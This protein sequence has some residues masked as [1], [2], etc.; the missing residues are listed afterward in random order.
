M[1]HEDLQAKMQAL[2]TELRERQERER[3][4]YLLLID[5]IERTLGISPRTAEIREWYRRQRT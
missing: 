1:T 3:R 2:E 5:E 4:L